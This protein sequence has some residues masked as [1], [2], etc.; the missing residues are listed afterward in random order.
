MPT[1]Q[2]IMMEDYEV[3]DVMRRTTGPDLHIFLILEPNIINF[4]DDATFS[5]PITLTGTIV[6]RSDTP[7][8]YTIILIYVD[9]RINVVEREHFKTTGQLYF[10]DENKISYTLNGFFRNWTIPA[11]MPI[12]RGTS[13]MPINVKLTIPRA[14]GEYK[15][16]WQVESPEMFIKSEKLTLVVD[17]SSIKIKEPQDMTIFRR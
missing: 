17:G 7:A 13:F 2:S 10:P 5:L 8:F 4:E 1:F 6:N 9:E 11:M 16:V 12:W 14:D 15:L 3:K